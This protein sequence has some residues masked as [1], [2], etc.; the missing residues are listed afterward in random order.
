[1]NIGEGFMPEGQGGTYNH[2]G[3]GARIT[4]RLIQARD[5]TGSITSGP[6]G[7][8]ITGAADGENREPDDADVHNHVAA[9]VEIGGQLIQTRTITAAPGQSVRQRPRKT[10]KRFVWPTV[11]GALAVV[12]AVFTLYVGL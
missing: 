1:M 3:E 6:D 4:G 12:I 11:L 5:I 8:T 9:G 7:L 10:A 2:V